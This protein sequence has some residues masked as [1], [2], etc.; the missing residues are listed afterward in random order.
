MS[1]Y[2]GKGTP[3][4]VEDGSVEIE[5][6]S[7]TG[8]PS[9]TTF[10]RGDNSWQVVNSTPSITDNGDATA[11]TIDSSENVGIG[12]VP[13]TFS[14]GYTA[15]QLNGYAYNIAHSGGDH[16]ITNNAYFNTGWKYGKTSTAQKIQLASGKI[17]F[18]VAPS[19]TADSAISFTTAMTIDNSGGISKDGSFDG[20]GSSDD[21]YWNT[22]GGDRF[23]FHSGT[24]SSR[25]LL[26]FSNPN[27][28]VGKIETVG[29]GTLYNT[30]NGGGIDFSGNANASGMTSE[31]LD[32]LL[33]CILVVLLLE[34]LILPKVVH[35]QK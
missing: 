12:V 8:T 2:I 3:V 24:T 34:L 22:G 13:D 16:Y 20:T 4:A 19:G 15:L 17:Q 10:L 26:G 35:I 28:V 1:G 23:R 21:F 9:S 32:E 11:I 29:S 25:D 18:D 33:L 7:A 30:G 14:S 5:D 6:L 31:V 27:G